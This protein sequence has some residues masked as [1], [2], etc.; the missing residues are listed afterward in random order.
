LPEAIA[1]PVRARLGQ[2]ILSVTEAFSALLKEYQ[3]DFRPDP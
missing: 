2:T 3:P 1:E